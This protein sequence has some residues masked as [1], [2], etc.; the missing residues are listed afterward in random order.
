MDFGTD[1]ASPEMMGR[2]KVLSAEEELLS[3]AKRSDNDRTR[4]QTGVT[5]P[6]SFTYAMPFPS[7]PDE[8]PPDRQLV[9]ARYREDLT[10]LTRVEMPIVVYCKNPDCSDPGHIHLPNTK[11]EAGTMLHHIVSNYHRLARLTYFAQG[12]PFDHARDF[13]KRLNVIYEQPTS[14]TLQYLRNHPAPDVKAKDK[15]E[16]VQG[17]VV[18]Y[19]DATHKGHA[20]TTEKG[21]YD[22]AT[23]PYI[24][25]CPQPKPLWFAYGAMWAV[26]R[27]AIRARPLALWRH[28]LEVCDRA[29]D[30][31]SERWTNPPINPWMMEASWYYLFQNPRHYP[32]HS[33]WDVSPRLTPHQVDA[34]TQAVVACQHRVPRPDD[35]E[36]ICALGNGGLD[37]RIGLVDCAACLQRREANA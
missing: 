19:G 9:V 14:L 22:P 6:R 26:P 35:H 3:Q 32:H 4:D 37:G 21:W 33:Q 15:V 34:L 36:A 5:G 28:L 2:S 1:A 20:P 23:W 17:F 11:R 25:N 27:E 18:R 24:F 13:L 7:P 30:N 29:L 8:P 10:W 31:C 16:V 12:D